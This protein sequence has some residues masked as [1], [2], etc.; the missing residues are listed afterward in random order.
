VVEAPESQLKELGLMLDGG[1]IM[2]EG[3]EDR[4]KLELVKQMGRCDGLAFALE[5]VRQN[6][7][8]GN[9]PEELFRELDR[10]REETVPA[11]PE[12]GS[13][14]SGGSDRSFVSEREGASGGDETNGSDGTP[15]EKRKG[16]R[17]RRKKQVEGGAVGARKQW[18]KRLYRRPTEEDRRGM[19]TLLLAGESTVAA[20]AKYGVTGPVAISAARRM[21]Y[22]YDRADRRW[23]KKRKK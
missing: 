7:G 17:G 5:L 16:R 20:A 18:E 2:A 14:E 23:K 4:L 9:N 13:D 3:I 22:V 21:G 12:D 19:V 6:G 1:R 15:K 10:I 11:L 8:S